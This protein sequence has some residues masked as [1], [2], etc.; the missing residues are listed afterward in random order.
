MARKFL[1]ALAGW[2]AS[3]CVLGILYNLGTETHLEVFNCS[4]FTNFLEYFVVLEAAVLATEAVCDSRSYE[5]LVDTLIVLIIAIF[6]NELTNPMLFSG[7]WQFKD[8][9]TWTLVSVIL[10]TL[11]AAIGTV[12]VGKWAFG[13]KKK[14]SE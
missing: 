5:V 14:S 6:G 8:L 9:V 7:V 1:A 10:S 11:V 13:G 4:K 12:N 2:F 3:F